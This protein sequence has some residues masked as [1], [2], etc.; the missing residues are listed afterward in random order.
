MLPFVSVVI[1]MLDEEARI[2]ECL[3]SV[4]DQR[5][6]PGRFEVLVVDG[7]SSDASPA[8]AARFAREH[9]EVRLITNARRGTWASRRRRTTP[10]SR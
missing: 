9:P 5:Y 10:I 2:A 1:P 4:V 3:Q 7:G 8:I 6:Q